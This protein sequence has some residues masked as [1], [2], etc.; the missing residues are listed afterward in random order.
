MESDIHR[1]QRARS[2]ALKEL[3]TLKT[4][5][6]RGGV[7]WGQEKMQPFIIKLFRRIPLAHLVSRMSAGVTHSSGSITRWQSNGLGS[8]CWA[9]HPGPASN[10]AGDLGQVPAP[11]PPPTGPHG[12]S[13][14]L[15]GLD[16][17]VLLR[18][19]PESHFFF[20]TG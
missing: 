8:S 7:A 5:L 11:Q 15:L 19:T 18:S 10:S 12:L 9:S 2:L 20:P 16:L 13:C 1:P 17:M 14:K 6:R 3:S 4:R